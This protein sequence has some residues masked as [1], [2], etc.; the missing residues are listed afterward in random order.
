MHYSITFT[1]SFAGRVSTVADL[2]FFFWHAILVLSFIGADSDR[3]ITFLG[4]RLRDKRRMIWKYWA[5]S[6][7]V[8]FVIG[9]LNW[10]LGWEIWTP[11]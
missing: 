9:V 4:V 10:V 7:G 8:M 5:I 11:A 6:L 2:W 3:P 1:S